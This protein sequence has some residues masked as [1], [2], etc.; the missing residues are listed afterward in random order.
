MAVS[1]IG[2]R[3]MISIPK[4]YVTKPCSFMERRSD[5]VLEAPAVVA[6]LD[7]VAMMSETVEQSRCHLRIAEHAGPFAERQIGRHDHRGALV[8]AADQME[9]ELSASLC[10]WQVTKF[11]EDDEVEAGGGFEEGPVGE[12]R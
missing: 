2:L 5:A 9:Q 3:G 4:R 1:P 8:E 10:E 11:I 12:R 7:D 6:G